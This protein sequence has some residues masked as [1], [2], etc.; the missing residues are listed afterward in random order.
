M[1]RN[2]LQGDLQP[3]MAQEFQEKCAPACVPF[4]SLL[5]E[6][7]FALLLVCQGI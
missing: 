7:L 4:W 2:S 5:Y 6:Y 3:A 1:I